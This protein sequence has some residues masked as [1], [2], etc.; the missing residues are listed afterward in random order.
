MSS[1][2]R[3][4]SIKSAAA[5]VWVCS[6]PSAVRG[7][8]SLGDYPGNS[9]LVPPLMCLETAPYR[10]GLRHFCVRSQVRSPRLDRRDL[11]PH[12]EG[13][14]IGGDSSRETN[15]PIGG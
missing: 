15:A 12:S 11:Y 9:E 10:S 13:A 5:Q 7:A 2:S 8:D 3:I 1:T 6:R 4:R 14:A